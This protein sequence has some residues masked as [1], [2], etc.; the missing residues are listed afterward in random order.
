MVSVT[1]QHGII[2][3]QPAELCYYINA[4]ESYSNTV[5]KSLIYANDVISNRV[6]AEVFLASGSC[7]LSS[8]KW[9]WY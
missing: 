6:D 3:H 5:I 7:F 1:S 2:I 4:L 8:G 9:K